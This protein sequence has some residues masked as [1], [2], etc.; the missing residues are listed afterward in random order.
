MLMLIDSSGPPGD[1]GGS[2]HEPWLVALLGWVLPWPAL[3][4]W[5]CAASRVVDGWA[6]VG[7]VF[8]AVGL[9]AWRGLHA[10]PTE[11]LDEGRQ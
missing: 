4:V 8:V 1:D 11:G 10:L 7:A 9:A 3:I 2:T 5:L 6:G